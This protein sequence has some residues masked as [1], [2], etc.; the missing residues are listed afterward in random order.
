MIR[1]Y[2]FK[3]IIS[4][5]IPDRKDIKILAIEKDS[6]E[7]EGRKLPRHLILRMNA[8]ARKKHIWEE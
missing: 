5:A 6:V 4:V 7:V 3:E 2:K 8:K 1:K